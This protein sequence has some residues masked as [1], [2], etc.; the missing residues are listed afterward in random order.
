MRLILK[1]CYMNTRVIDSNCLPKV[2]C[3]QVQRIKA[4]A[5]VFSLLVFTLL[6]F[7]RYTYIHVLCSRGTGLPCGAEK[8]ST[9]RYRHQVCPAL[10]I[11]Y[12]ANDVGIGPTFSLSILE[13]RP[14]SFLNMQFSPDDDE[15]HI[16]ERLY[17]LARWYGLVLGHQWNRSYQIANF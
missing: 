7:S 13:S 1:T 17:V 3:T 12:R 15:N 11:S 5:N 2:R 16:Q 8:Q 9:P 10:P 4:Q 6:V 14:V